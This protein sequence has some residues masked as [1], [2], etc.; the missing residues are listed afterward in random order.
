MMGFHS[1]Q[2]EMFS[3][4]VNL[5]QR[6]RSDNPLRA[7]R[8]R[9]DFSWVRPEVARFYGR[10]GNVSVDPEVVMKLMFLLFFENVRSERELMRILPE[11]LDYLWFLG[12]GLDDG[13]PDHSVLSKARARWGR[14]V[15]ES[16]FVKT[17]GSCVA[18]GLVDGSKVHMDGSLVDADAS[19]DSVVQSSPELIAA[20]KA[21]YGVEEAKLSGN[22]GSPHYQPVNA[23]LCSSTDPDAP[24]VRQ[25]KSGAQGGSRPRYKHH[26]AVDDRCGVITAVATTPGDVAEPAMAEAL[27]DA[28]EKHTGMRAQTAVA[29]QQYGTAEIHRRLQRRG[30]TTHLKTV[31]GRPADESK[32][33][34]S[35]FGY[36]ADGD[37]CICPA[38]KRMNRRRLDE[39]RQT[40]EY[41]SAKG[42][43]DGCPLRQRCTSSPHGRVVV[44][45]V[46]HEL[47]EKARAQARSREAWRDYARRRHLIEG[48]FGQAATRHGFKRAR[49]RRLWR[50]EIQDLLIA[51]IQNVKILVGALG[52]QTGAGA[53]KAAEA[54][55]RAENGL[56]EERKGPLWPR[57]RVSGRIRAL[58]AAWSGM[59]AGSPQF[60]SLISG[61]EIGFGR[62]IV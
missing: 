13:I 41:R 32:F 34:V 8:E 31:T 35:D 29:D 21:A 12:F 59:R 62:T 22:L 39:R 15:F 52:P 3:Y 7:I 55:Q 61:Y 54:A 1:G 36:D 14:D 27:I 53:G 4:S 40:I 45:H 20:L 17:I 26:R 37:F 43:C 18:A 5:D 19:R 23:E 44:R 46:D 33:A 38:G 56:A 48:S 10:N 24:C 2:K 6:V 30:V 16:L 42:A 51:A 47:V 11:R 9:I 60:L 25:S 49:W 28:H 58:Q 50:Q 57:F